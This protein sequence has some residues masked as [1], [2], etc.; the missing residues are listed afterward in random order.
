MKIG[1]KLILGFVGI[2][3]L[4]EIVGYICLNASQKALQES[5]AESSASL[6]AATLDRIDRG[7][8]SRIKEFQ[9]YSEDS[10][11]QKVTEESNEKFEKLDDIQSYIEQKD[12][13]WTSAPKETV[14][15]F[16][17]ELISNRLSEELRRRRKFYEEEYYYQLFSEVFVTN[18]YGANVAQTGKTTDYRQDDEEW[19]QAAK[20][21]GLYV[22]DVKY[23]ESAH[24]YSTDIG[25]RIED[26]AGNF[27]GVMKVG[28]NIE[29]A[30]NVIRETA[31]PGVSRWHKTMYFKLLT[32]NNKII[33]STKS[34]F[35]IL[36]NITT[37]LSSRFEQVEEAG[38]KYYLTTK[39]DE[40]SKKE[41]LFVR[42]QSRGYK[43]YKGLGWILVV[44]QETQEIFAP[45]ARLR[46]S[47]LLVP[48]AATTFAF[49]V[50]LFISHFISTPITRLKDAAAEI[51]AGNFD[52]N[53]EI[54]SNDEIGQLSASFKRM[55]EGLKVSTTSIHKLNNEITVRKK[56]EDALRESEEK[57]K[58]LTDNS[59]T[60]VFIQQDGRYVFVNDRFAQI[61]N[62]GPEE[63]L[64][65]EYQ[66]LIHPDE[67][68][69]AAQ[70]VSKRLS[71]E[72]VTQR[73]EMRRLKKN[74]QAV[75]CEVMASR[76]DYRGRPALMA[77]IIDISERKKAEEILEKL[78]KDLESAVK[79]LSRSNQELQE[80]TYVAAH[81]LKSPLRAI[82][83]LADWILTD[84]GDKFDEKGRQE[85]DL[86]VKRVK[87]MDKVIDSILQYSEVRRATQEDQDVDL[88]IVL[89]EVIGEIKPP[90]NVQI[91]IESELP[92]VTCDKTCMMHVFGNMLRNAVKYMDK[93]KAQIKVGCVE[94]DA[95][96]KFSIA[97]NGPGIEEKY[98]KK[99]FEIFQTLSRHDESASTGIGLSIV[100]KIVNVYGGRVWVESSLG[101]GSTFFFTLP[102]QEQEL[103]DAKLKAN[104]AC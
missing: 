26:E 96:W 76:V 11:L 23:D 78:N 16:M 81:D 77:N 17:Q 91:T 65:K 30:I 41:R 51:G 15:A 68:E 34:G 8:Y 9:S 102:K 100:K 20:K 61:H 29:Q 28:L 13:E 7:I 44:E 95:F 87:R 83:T 67:K 93:P 33:Y 89:S 35:Q 62:Y 18:K 86:L 60:G 43:D 54:K 19:W 52:T 10:V 66:S 57:Y 40:P 36:E 3:L 92:T 1:Q 38:R 69:T 70:I 2:A 56:T 98:F 47:L 99:I 37:D 22:R 101:E 21:D 104:I 58:T 53:I 97:D 82:G 85:V 32:K 90:E 80:F 31:L 73:Y 59:L 55:A 63:L 71:G 46:K 39:T 25:I 64:G 45:V 24:V 94:E 42:A 48:F 14:T 103:T 72:E 88:N 27:V 74:G 6:A 84:Y 50:A 12:K 49:V 4:I 75:W 5:I 79:E